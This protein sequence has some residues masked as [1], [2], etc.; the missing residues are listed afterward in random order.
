MKADHIHPGQPDLLG[1]LLDL[2]MGELVEGMGP[3]L[4]GEVESPQPDRFPRRRLE[5]E[6]PRPV[7]PEPAATV[8]VVALHILR[9]I[10][11]G[12]GNPFPL[13]NP[14]R[15]DVLPLD[16]IHLHRPPL[17]PPLEFGNPADL[18]AERH[19]TADEL[20]ARRTAQ[21]P[22]RNQVPPLLHR[23]IEDVIGRQVGG[24]TVAGGERIVDQFA[25]DEEFE[26]VISRAADLH[27]PI[28]FRLELVEE[29]RGAFLPRR[30]AVQRNIKNAVPQFHRPAGDAAQRFRNS[31]HLFQQDRFQLRRQEER[32]LRIQCQRENIHH[33]LQFDAPHQKA[34]SLRE[35][36]RHQHRRTDH[37]LI[38]RFRRELPRNLLPGGGH[39]KV[40]LRIADHRP[41]LLILNAVRPHLCGAIRLDAE[42]ITVTSPRHN[43]LFRR[44]IDLKTPGGTPFLRLQNRELPAGLPRRSSLLRRT[45]RDT[46]GIVP[47]SRDFLLAQIPL[48]QE[49]RTGQ[50]KRHPGQKNTGQQIIH[51]LQLLSP[52]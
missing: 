31:P 8:D 41:R 47:H 29:H 33:L 14:L 26:P 16:R 15:R 46:F 24:L 19:R 43:R 28:L 20:P 6:P 35:F 30:T 37:A 44:K 17:L 39:G 21:H 25:V 9:K 22:D 32:P 13:V 42:A 4:G 49:F 5:I 11:R 34:G 23:E 27:D 18:L 38:R 7:R 48:L 51:T 52:L 50:R 12:T 36:P 10:E 2:R 3:A 45:E 40:A 1:E